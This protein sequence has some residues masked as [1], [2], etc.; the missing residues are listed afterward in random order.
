VSLSFF[1]ATFFSTDFVFNLKF[2]VFN[3]Q[4]GPNQQ[5]SAFGMRTPNGTIWDWIFQPI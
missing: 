1:L 3:P 2:A 5:K 4:N